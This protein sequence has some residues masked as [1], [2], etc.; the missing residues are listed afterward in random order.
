MLMK[1]LLH[2][3]SVKNVYKLDDS[4]C[5]FEFSD[6]I[7]VFDKIIP[8]QIPG[9]G[10]ALCDMTCFWFALLGE[11]NIHHHF[12]ERSGP[13]S[14]VVKSVSI[15]HD[16]SKIIDGKTNHLVP[17]E[18]IVRHYVAG[19][20]YDR[21]QKGKVQS[22]DLGFASS[23]EI[24]YGMKLPTPY[25]EMSTKLEPVDRLLSVEEAIDIARMSRA[26]LEEIKETIFTIDAEMDRRLE[27][28]NLIHVD[29]KK[30][31]GYDREGNLMVVDVFG[32]ADEDR[33]WDRAKYE[34]NGECV[35]FSKEAVR[36]HY[37]Q[38]GYKD[39][40]YT[41][42]EKGVDEPPIPEL[43]EELVEEISQM[44]RSIA[45]QVCNGGG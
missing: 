43:P 42:R 9:K 36:Q 6:R 29:G 26:R 19:S 13:E 23:D 15:I 14:I 21:L 16:Y 41:A 8:S 28:T 24:G 31:F 30:E 40:L 39:E 2:T 4:T 3:G 18:F 7:S 5:E 37:H 32:T 10:R 33:Y 27:S 25:F 34:S 12:I 35:Q 44:Y 1:E 45:D 22:E 38:T 11:V 20:I 17:L